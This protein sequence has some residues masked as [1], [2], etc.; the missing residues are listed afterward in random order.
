MFDRM[1]Q[2]SKNAF[3]TARTLAKVDQAVQIDTDHLLVALVGNEDCVACQLLI[4]AGVVPEKARMAAKA[5]Q[6]EHPREKSKGGEPSY[7]PDLKAVMEFAETFSQEIEAD[8]IFTEH[9]LAA[10]L[11]METGAATDI[12]KKM[13]VNIAKVMELIADH[14][15]KTQRA[16]GQKTIDPA[17]VAPVGVV[18]YVDKNVQPKS[19]ANLMG[20][21]AQFKGVLGCDVIEMKPKD[22]PPAQSSLHVS[23]APAKTPGGI[24]IG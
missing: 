3:D 18:V 19:L 13:N 23:Q 12:F 21:I 20:A 15:E 6:A 10:L 16:P 1:S 7:S 5:L 14:M 4:A 2:Q 8:G 9:L 17:D 22:A 24:F 11:K